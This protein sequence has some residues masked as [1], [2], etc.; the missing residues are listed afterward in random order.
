MSRAVDTC[1]MC[2]MKA[3][4]CR[5]CGEEEARKRGRIEGMGTK[6]KAV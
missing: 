2:D 4:E 1:Y 3:E 6:N 5:S